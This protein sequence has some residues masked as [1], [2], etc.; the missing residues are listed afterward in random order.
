MSHNAVEHQ[1]R[2]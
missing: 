2:N 1:L